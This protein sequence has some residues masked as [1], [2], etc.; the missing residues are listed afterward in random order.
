M[1]APVYK[2]LAEPSL[3]RGLELSHQT[4]SFTSIPA[5]MQGTTQ[6]V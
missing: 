1:L 3:L 5:S 2:G 6:H 4:V